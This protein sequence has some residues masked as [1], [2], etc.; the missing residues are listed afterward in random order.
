MLQ[1]L[2]PYKSGRPSIIYDSTCP[3]PLRKLSKSCARTYSFLETFGLERRTVLRF[4]TQLDDHL[5]RPLKC[6]AHYRKCSSHYR[7]CS[8]HLFSLRQT[9]VSVRP[10]HSDRFPQNTDLLDNFSDDESVR[11]AQT[12][13]RQSSGT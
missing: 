6:S 9:Q 12:D 8:A 10:D 2:I 13:D 4:R 7:K 3:E 1:D 11:P 5:K